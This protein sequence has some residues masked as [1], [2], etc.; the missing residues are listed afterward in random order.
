MGMDT[1]QID[2]LPYKGCTVYDGSGLLAAYHYAVS[3]HSGYPLLSDISI[4]MVSGWQVGLAGAPSTNSDHD[5]L[6]SFP[7][8]QHLPLSQSDHPLAG[9]AP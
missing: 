4:R 1:V 6:S 8:L 9:T 7:S 3:S 5:G 2:S